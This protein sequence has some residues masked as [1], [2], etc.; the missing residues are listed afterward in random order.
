MVSQEVKAI[1]TDIKNMK[2]RGAGLIARS[3]VKALK[4]TAMNSKA[5]DKDSLKEEINIVARILKETR[6]SAVSLPNGINFVMNRFNKLFSEDYSV[7]DL[8]EGI[9]LSAEEFIDRSLV[10]I[11]RIGEIGANR[12]QD[13]DKIMTICNSSCVESILA[14]AKKQ[15]KE[16]TVFAAETRPRYQGHITAKKLGELGISTKL[17][18]DGAIRTFVN[19]MDLC[20]AGADSVTANGSVINK[21]GTSMM[22]LAAHEARTSLYIATETYKFSPES[23]V[24]RLI[25]IEERDHSEV[26][27][28]NKLKT[29]K[30]VAIKNPSF[31]ITPN[32]YIELIITERGIIFGISKCSINIELH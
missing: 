29:M 11:Q 6:P 17:I 2:I 32:E 16:I 30:N 9:E 25:E 20:L 18:V 8:I 22:A 24:G 4:L 28:I 3:A 13:G 15:N 5:K 23:M 19:K 21:V 1:A 7:K 27:D 31:D 10:A 26:L 12:I 14:T